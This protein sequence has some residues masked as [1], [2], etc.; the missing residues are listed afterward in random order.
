[1]PSFWSSVANSVA[2]AIGLADQVLD[3]VALERV[4]HGRLR[5]GERERTL[6]GQG[7][8]GLGDAL[9]Q[10]ARARRRR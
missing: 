9:H 6:R 5:G 3:V 4:V 7:A 10:L 8:G 2:E 1:M